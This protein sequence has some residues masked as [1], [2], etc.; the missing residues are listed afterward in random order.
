MSIFLRDIPILTKIA[1]WLQRIY[2]KLSKKN[3]FILIQH[4]LTYK[5]L[6][7]FF[8][9]NLFYPFFLIELGVLGDRSLK[10]PINN[11][12]IYSCQHS[13]S[14]SNWSKRCYYFSEFCC[15]ESVYTDIHTNIN[16][17]KFVFSWTL[18]SCVNE[19]ICLR[20]W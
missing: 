12:N 18:N 7:N 20:V 4:L 14:R 15:C 11:R 10:E 2:R 8:L 19:K 13:A 5:L 6:Y 17:H 16:T 1:S 3:S 9:W